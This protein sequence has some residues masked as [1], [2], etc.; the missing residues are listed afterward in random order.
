MLLISLLQLCERNMAFFADFIYLRTRWFSDFY[1]TKDLHYWKLL[2]NFINAS[3]ILLRQTFF[4][5]S[6]RFAYNI[7]CIITSS[8][9]SKFFPPELYAIYFTTIL[10]SRWS[11]IFLI[12]FMNSC[13]Q[14]IYWTLSLFCFFPILR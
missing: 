4:W 12:T 1:Q 8:I 11:M 10:R 6:C 9:N 13:F 14:W 5:L 2:Q 7:Y 3:I